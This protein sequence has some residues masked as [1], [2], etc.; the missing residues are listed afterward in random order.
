MN[1]KNIVR[2]LP[3]YLD[4]FATCGTA[5]AASKAAGISRAT[6]WRA[7]NL[8]EQGAP[9]LQ[10]IAWGGT[11][12]PFHLH[13]IDI[14][15]QAIESI[16]QDAT[17]AAWQGRF[18]EPVIGG[19]YQFEDCEFAMSL[20]PKQFEEQLVLDEEVRDMCG[21]P[22]V[23]HDKKKRTLNPKTGTWERV[24]TKQFIPPTIDLQA[25]ILSAFSPETFGDKRRVDVTMQG[26]L[27]VS[28]GLPFGSKPPIQLR[29]A[30]CPGD[31]V[32]RC[33]AG[34]RDFRSRTGAGG[35]AQHDRTATL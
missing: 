24:R 22:R 16:Q 15:D 35:T 18:V 6:I 29:G 3:G 2:L 13:L 32:Q 34:H 20:T 26:S 27:G 9:E 12:Q 10:E 14:L 21:F 31:R 19:I 11:T 17:H 7:A 1:Y 23:W 30:G 5:T 8:S 28:V 33:R 4:A 25:K